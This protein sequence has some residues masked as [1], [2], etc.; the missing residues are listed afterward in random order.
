MARPSKLTPEISAAICQS[1]R[2]TKL[3][4]RDAARALGLHE[5]TVF[6]WIERGRREKRGKFSEFSVAIS[7]A[8]AEGTQVLLARIAK[9]G[10]NPTHWQANAHLLQMTE[11]AYALKVRLEIG[12]QLTDAIDRLTETFK[13][14]P[15]V[16]E[17]AL[18]AI[19]GNNDGEEDDG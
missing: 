13:D 8:R 5:D 9:A 17:R 16:L 12:K 11:P 1:I 18:A 4:V 7:K 15:L 6:G 14:E 10:T 2:T 3:S 19:A